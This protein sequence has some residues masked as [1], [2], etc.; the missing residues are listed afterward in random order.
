[1]LGYR[2]IFSPFFP[3]FPCLFSA[4]AHIG[5]SLCNIF[6]S[7]QTQPTYLRSC[8]YNMVWGLWHWAVLCIVDILLENWNT[9]PHSIHHDFHDRIFILRNAFS[10]E[11]GSLGAG[12]SMCHQNSGGFFFFSTHFC[13]YAAKEPSQQGHCHTTLLCQ[14]GH[15]CPTRL[16]RRH[17]CPELF[18]YEGHP[19]W[20]ILEDGDAE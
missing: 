7:I 8:G 1:M 6:A 12:S 14:E 15:L 2:W 9:P 17:L 19:Y 4:D 10:V 13:K 11:H 5:S 18:Q 16:W 3:S 20:G